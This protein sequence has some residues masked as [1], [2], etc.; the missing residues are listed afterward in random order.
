MVTVVLDRSFLSLTLPSLP[1]NY[2]CLRTQPWVPHPPSSSQDA[3]SQ[4]HNEMHCQAARLFLYSLEIQ[5]GGAK[6]HF[7]YLHFD[8][9]QLIN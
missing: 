1:V 5:Y 8:C 7:D 9:Q 4:I 6:R 3:S 2:I